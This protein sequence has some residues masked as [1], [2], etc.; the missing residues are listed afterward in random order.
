MNEDIKN[1]AKENNIRLWR[2]AEKLGVSDSNFSRMLRYKLS[3]E[4]KDRIL[5]VIKE[6]VIDD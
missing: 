3:K 5:A 4:D 2:V 1:I 6:L